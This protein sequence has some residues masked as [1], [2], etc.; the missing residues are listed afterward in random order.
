MLYLQQN[1]IAKIEN[2][3][4]LTNLVEINL[5]QN[6]IT[7]VE[8]LRGLDNL[9]NLD[10]KDNL[11][12]TVDDCQELLEL[13]SLASLDLKSNNIADRDEKILEFFGQFADLKS[14]YLKGNPCVRFISMYRK[15]ITAEMPSLTYLD[16]RPIYEIERI[17]IDAF[18]RGGAEEEERVRSEYQQK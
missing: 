3:S 15:R 4:H 2:I 1:Q 9:K 5:A 11:I 10:L 7:K 13:P 18:K 17:T 6:H 8:G 16:D 12:S 14:L